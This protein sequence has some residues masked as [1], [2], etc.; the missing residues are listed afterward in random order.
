MDVDCI[1]DLFSF[2][3]WHPREKF[4][5]SI[6]PDLARKD[7]PEIIQGG[8]GKFCKQYP[9]YIWRKY[10]MFDER[11]HAPFPLG[12]I[13]DEDDKSDSIVRLAPKTGGFTL[14]TPWQ[15]TPEV[16][17]K[18]FEW[19]WALFDF[20]AP[21]PFTGDR[22]FL[23]GPRS[24]TLLDEVMELPE[25]FFGLSDNRQLCEKFR[26][27]QKEYS[28]L[29]GVPELIYREKDIERILKDIRTV[30]KLSLSY[31][32]GVLKHSNRY[33]H[34]LGN[35]TEWDVFLYCRPKVNYIRAGRQNGLHKHAY[36]TEGTGTAI[37]EFIETKPGKGKREVEFERA[38]YRMEDLMLNIYPSFKLGALLRISTSKKPQRSSY[39][40]E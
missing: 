6:L 23:P 22:K 35:P 5:Q 17:R 16:F 25:D 38:Y 13:L 10:Y 29:F 2:D 37:Q 27:Y 40:R 8:L 28:L 1:D 12:Q 15:G 39:I 32:Q 26:H 18:H 9:F 3:D 19:M 4:I 11:K 21:N 31:F 30:L 34:L 24:V 33:P 36:R 20:N 14:G 7:I